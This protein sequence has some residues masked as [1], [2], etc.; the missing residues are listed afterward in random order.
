V[1][2]RSSNKTQ[3]QNS[4]G[5][6]TKIPIN[7][8]SKNHAD[9][10]SD[11]GGGGG[12]EALLGSQLYSPHLAPHDLFMLLKLNIYVEGSSFEPLVDILSNAT[13]VLKGLF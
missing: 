4:K 11:M 8:K 7:E 10:L 3:K 12:G 13:T 5:P 6:N 1:R 2:L 9:L